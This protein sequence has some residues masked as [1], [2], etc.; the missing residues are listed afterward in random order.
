M[1]FCLTKQKIV[2]ENNFCRFDENCRECNNSMQV[3]DV[4]SITKML[5]DEKINF[6]ITKKFDH[7]EITIITNKGEF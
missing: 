1:L 7:T 5:N 4:E 6:C 2:D 3:Y